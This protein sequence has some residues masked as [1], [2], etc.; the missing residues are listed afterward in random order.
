[1]MTKQKEV[2]NEADLSAR[3][4]ANP[5][6]HPACRFVEKTIA[7]IDLHLAICNLGKVNLKPMHPAVS[8]ICGGLKGF[9]CHA[10]A[11]EL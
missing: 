7:R 8:M 6:G 3:R 9:P 10:L 1:M 4:K 11:G 5:C 2:A